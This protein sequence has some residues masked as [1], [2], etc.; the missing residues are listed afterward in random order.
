MQGKIR[1][2][3]MVVLA[4]LVSTGV[5]WA[6]GAKGTLTGSDDSEPPDES[7]CTDGEEQGLPP[8]ED[9]QGGSGG[10]GEL[11][12]C[13]HASVPGGGPIPDA[14]QMVEECSNDLSGGWS[15]GLNALGL[16]TW[17]TDDPVLEI[18]W[19]E[20]IA[21]IDGIQLRLDMPDG[22]ISTA[23]LRKFEDMPAGD[24]SGEDNWVRVVLN[25]VVNVEDDPDDDV[26]DEYIVTTSRKALHTLNADIKSAI[27]ADYKTADVGDYLL[28]LWKR[29]VNQT[30]IHAIEV[31]TSDEGIVSTE[32]ALEPLNYHPFTSCAELGESPI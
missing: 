8:C 31:Y 6:D 32:L 2:L 30:P 1:I 5:A 26:Y 16:P 13:Y 10:A 19:R 9:E 3:L 17:S 28:I 25:R 11:D 29:D 23:K 22:Y 18:C 24:P 12:T 14:L 4:V 15:W 7:Q 27:E 21:Q 20:E